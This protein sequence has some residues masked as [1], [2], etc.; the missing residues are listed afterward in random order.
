M[1]KVKRDKPRCPLTLC[2][3]VADLFFRKP[4]PASN[5]DL[6][7]LYI[8]LPLQH[9]IAAYCIGKSFTSLEGLKYEL[10]PF[11]FASI[12]TDLNGARLRV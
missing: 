4:K 8:S 9:E 5:P 6:A 12:C 11:G 10:G 7:L 2:P 3:H 1:H